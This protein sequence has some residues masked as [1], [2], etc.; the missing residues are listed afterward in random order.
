MFNY[1][2]PVIWYHI[3]K[4]GYGYGIRVLAKI[5]KVNKHSVRIIVY[6]KVKNSFV[7]KS[8]KSFSLRTPTSYEIGLI[9]QINW[10]I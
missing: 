9:N 10:V 6:N 2:E 3:P 1:L 4:G 8:V 7:K 5:L